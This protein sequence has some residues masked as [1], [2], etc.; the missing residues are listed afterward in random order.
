MSALR[1]IKLQHVI[2]VV[3][4]IPSKGVSKSR[5]IPSLGEEATLTVAEALLLDTY[6]ESS[7]LNILVP[8]FILMTMCLNLV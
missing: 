7:P 3:A 4:K 6:D 8:N 1:D 5:L 2:V